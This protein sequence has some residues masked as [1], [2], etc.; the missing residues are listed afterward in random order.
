[1][2]GGENP[3]EQR[4]PSKFWESAK[5]WF[6]RKIGDAPGSETS[7]QQN[8]GFDKETIDRV[9]ERASKLLQSADPAKF[10]EKFVLPVFSEGGVRAQEMA[11]LMGSQ[12]H[13]LLSEADRGDI[14]WWR[15]EKGHTGYFLITEPYRDEKGNEAYGIGA[16]KA[17]IDT[18]TIESDKARVMGASFGGMLWIRKIA[19][20]VPV[21]FAIPNVATYR[22][23]PVEK[24]GIVKTDALAESR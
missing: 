2:E 19:Q 23:Y 13:L 7:R 3:I 20:N 24:M 22:T 1:M 21:E 16:I 5:K 14:V 6:G 9:F 12:P 18:G 15:D 10:G 4:K 11:E 8:Q 17:E